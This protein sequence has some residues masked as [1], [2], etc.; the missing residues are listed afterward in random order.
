MTNWILVAS[1]LYLFIF[2][3]L[4]HNKSVGPSGFLVLSFLIPSVLVLFYDDYFT[5]YV[6]IDTILIVNVLI[7]MFSLGE[8]TQSRKKQLICNKERSLPNLY[9]HK[10][11]FYLFL[12]IVL[13]NF[14][15]QYRYLMQIGTLMGASNLISAYAASRLV[16]VEYQNTGVIDVQMPF[17]GVLI[18]IIASCV[19]IVCLH[20]YI[21]N[22]VFKRVNHNRIL[23]IIMIYCVSLFFST[24]RAAFIPVFIHAI[25]ITLLFLTAR[26]PIRQ[27]L[28]KYYRKIIVVVMVVSSSFLLLGALRQNI[29]GDGDIE[30]DPSFTL[31]TYIAAPILGLDIYIN[32]KMKPS[33]YIGEHT[34]KDYYDYARIFGAKYKRSQFHKEDFYV[35]KGSSNVYTGFYY[36]LSDFSFWG[37]CLYSL[38]LGMLIGYFYYK[39]T[40]YG[41]IV[42]VYF[43]SYLY[44]SLILMF[45]D[46]QFN[47]IFSVIM[48][49]KIILISYMQ[50][51]CVRRV[52]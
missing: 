18:S 10:N 6:S 15:V 3:Y 45:Y 39:G 37:A 51:K 43:I 17:Y 23:L 50:R 27:V 35:G 26:M 28:K 4:L 47:V 44:Y 42:R 16:L 1:L 38:F 25:Y 14:L 20:I 11:V 46:D 36:W 9:I 29:D 33:E 52:L 21:Y 22:R 7:V 32:N 34:F 12:L 19:E 2:L 13:V 49:F 31:K 5:T 8:L 30:V 41:N 24:G 48:M 40:N